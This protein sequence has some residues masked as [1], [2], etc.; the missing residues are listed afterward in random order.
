M[1]ES[2]KSP[3]SKHGL[4]YVLHILEDVRF[5]HNTNTHACNCDICDKKSSLITSSLSTAIDEIKCFASCLQVNAP[6]SSF[7][8]RDSR[9]SG[10]VSTTLGSD[11]KTNHSLYMTSSP[12][13]SSSH[14][15]N[16]NGC[17]ESLIPCN[18]STPSDNQKKD[19]SPL[20]AHFKPPQYFCNFQSL[21][22]SS[23]RTDSGVHGEN[24]LNSDSISRITGSDLP[25]SIGE[26]SDSSD[27][28]KSSPSSSSNIISDVKPRPFDCFYVQQPNINKSPVAVKEELNTAA[29]KLGL[30]KNSFLHN[31]PLNSTNPTL[32]MSNFSCIPIHPF[33]WPSS[34]YSKFYSTPPLPFLTK[35]S[36]ENF[37]GNQQ[38]STVPKCAFPN[39]VGLS[40]KIQ[41][42]GEYF[43]EGKN[44]QVDWPPV[45]VLHNQFTDATQL[46]GAF[47]S[48]DKSCKRDFIIPTS[49][50]SSFLDPKNPFSYPY[51]VIRKD[52][53][54]NGGRTSDDSDSFKINKLLTAESN[55]SPFGSSASL[56]NI[57]DVSGVTWRPWEAKEDVFKIL[58]DESIEEADSVDSI[59]SNNNES[60]LSEQEQKEQSSSINPSI[61]EAEQDGDCKEQNMTAKYHKISEILEYDLNK[62]IEHVNLKDEQMKENDIVFRR[63]AQNE[64]IISNFPSKLSTKDEST[65]SQ[66]SNIMN[67]NLFEEKSSNVNSKLVNEELPKK[68]AVLSPS[69]ICLNQSSSCLQDIS[70]TMK[71]KLSTVEYHSLK[72]ERVSDEQYQ[73]KKESN[74]YSLKANE[75]DDCIRKS[76]LWTSE[77][78]NN[79]KEVAALNNG[80]QNDEDLQCLEVV[81]VEVYSHPKTPQV[82]PTKG[83]FLEDCDGTNSKHPILSNQKFISCHNPHLGPNK[84]NIAETKVRALENSKSDIF[85]ATETTKKQDANISMPLRISK[86]IDMTVSTLLQEMNNEDNNE[87]LTLHNCGAPAIFVSHFD[88]ETNRISLSDYFD[89]NKT[90]L[91]NAQSTTKTDNETKCMEGDKEVTNIDNVKL[92][93]TDKSFVKDKSLEISSISLPRKMDRNTP[94]SASPS[95]DRRSRITAMCH[96]LSQLQLD[97]DRNHLNRSLPVSKLFSP[98]AKLLPIGNSFA[99]V[100]FEANQSFP[101]SSRK[102]SEG[103]ERG[104]FFGSKHHEIMG[105]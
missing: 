78:G 42:D 81:K 94:S 66:Y 15:V 60:D 17:N 46:E 9:E 75:K 54:L 89:E 98:E 82:T 95:I 56:F 37:R 85:L 26:S 100:S 88:G 51:D 23:T 84:T 79:L 8:S 72:R 65:N 32:A 6:S 99:S 103:Q 62:K 97:R 38:D 35:L 7:H 1:A 105:M 21:M 50:D 77:P 73:N 31:C 45:H 39:H 69:V 27:D 91:S 61:K 12:S 101:K 80:N 59:C 34:H 86:K 67:K 92:Y 22:L 70:N 90:N 96:E 83:T 76:T 16:A 68:Y 74:N 87:V 36:C 49:K 104:T 41:A 11:M 47:Q 58:S 55:L 44:G 64:C 30:P 5:L 4:G 71:P 53:M 29:S 102:A 52:I 24:F 2:N 40:A 14:C 13:G 19:Q 18:Q 48:C 10:C 63:T 20:T 33:S 43:L 57:T 3:S 28:Q 93:E 25:D